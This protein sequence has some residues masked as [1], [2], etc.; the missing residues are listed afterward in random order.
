MG[1]STDKPLAV[2]KDAGTTGSPHYLTSVIATNEMWI[3]AQQVHGISGAYTFAICYFALPCKLLLPWI[4]LIVYQSCKKLNNK[5]QSFSVGLIQIILYLNWHSILSYICSKQRVAFCQQ[6]V[7]RNS[8]NVLQY[9]GIFIIQAFAN[10]L[11]VQPNAK[12]FLKLKDWID[13][14][15]INCFLYA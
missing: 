14:D 8:T 15:P 12:T 2:Y 1:K 11:L 9:H 3:F 7:Q 6:V 5:T 13:I 4:W 10:F